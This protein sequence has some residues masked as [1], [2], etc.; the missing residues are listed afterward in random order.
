[1]EIQNKYKILKN[2]QRAID[3]GCA[4]GGW[5]QIITSLISSTNKKPLIAVD[6][7]KMN[8]LENVDFI[9]GDMTRP[10]IHELIF[11]KSN[12]EKFD[13]I[14]SDMCPEFVGNKF[15]DHSALINLNRMTI[16]FSSRFLKTNGCLVMKTFEGSMQKK[17]QEN[18]DIYFEKIHRFKPAS[19]RSESSEMYLICL[20][21]MEGQKLKDE[22]N[23]IEGSDMKEMLDKKKN[24]SL[25]NYKLKKFDDKFDTEELKVLREN[26]I[27]VFKVDPEDMKYEDDEI[28]EIKQIIEKERKEVS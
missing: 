3:V 11:E 20:G 8:S 23:K 21:F 7:L 12:Y 14:L 22:I 16:D 5:S 17:L 24:D 18:I 15:K 9:Q 1:M 2:G 27:N 26:I 25:R 6:I 19:S 13:V 10:Q 28:E 4:P